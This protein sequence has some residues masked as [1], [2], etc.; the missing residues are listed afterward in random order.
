MK[1]NQKSFPSIWLFFYFEGKRIDC[2]GITEGN[3][4]NLHK[5]A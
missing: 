2:Q 3:G 5:S 1:E 4:F